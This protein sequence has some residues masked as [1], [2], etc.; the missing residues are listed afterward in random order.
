MV[1]RTATP[2]DTATDTEVAVATAEV[3]VMEVVP[4]VV[5]TKCLA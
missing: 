5:V 3:E 2:M 4:T 1:I